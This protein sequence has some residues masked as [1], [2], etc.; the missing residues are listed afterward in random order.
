MHRKIGEGPEGAHADV[1]ASGVEYSTTPGI[2]LKPLSS[3]MRRYSRCVLSALAI[4]VS[5]LFTLVICYYTFTSRALP[6][7]LEDDFFRCGSSTQEAKAAGCHFDLLEFSWLPDEC[8]E[9]EIEQEFLSVRNWTYSVDPDGFEPLTEHQIINGDET[10]VHGTWEWHVTHCKFMAK[11][12][13]KLSTPGWVQYMNGNIRDRHHTE[14]CAKV[15]ADTW[16]PLSFPGVRVF[17]K[18]PAC[19]PDLQ[20]Y[21][22][23]GLYWLY[24]GFRIFRQ[25]GQIPMAL[26]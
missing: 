25:P 13:E 17:K 7:V 1:W 14:H 21:R 20:K 3:T 23:P 12:L 10:F 9:R 2:C 22:G 11:K 6:I 16:F 4:I 24:K 18:F 19:G 15:M 8:M 5:T 26:H